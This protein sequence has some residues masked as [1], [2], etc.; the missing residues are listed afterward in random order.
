MCLKT[1]GKEYEVWLQWLTR[2]LQEDQFKRNKTVTGHISHFNQTE[3]KTE[4]HRN[5]TPTAYH[6]GLA[7]LTMACFPM[8]LEPRIGFIFLTA[9]CR[10]GWKTYD[11]GDSYHLKYFPCGPLQEVC[12]LHSISLQSV[13]K[14]TF[15]FLVIKSMHSCKA[16]VGSTL[17]WGGSGGVVCSGMVCVCACWHSGGVYCVCSI[18]GGGGSWGVG[19]CMHSILG[20]VGVVGCVC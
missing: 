7:N 3:N 2:V 10:Q 16:T 19:M 6:E 17:G 9:G 14:D 18:L 8:V 13:H 11:L 1:S 12:W 4:C 15:C 5:T 20:G